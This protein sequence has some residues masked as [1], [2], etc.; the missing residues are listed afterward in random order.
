MPT[1]NWI[2]FLDG[3]QYTDTSEKWLASVKNICLPVG[4][5]PKNRVLGFSNQSL[6]LKWA[7][8]EGVLAGITDVID[9]N[10]IA[11]R[12]WNSL[13]ENQ[14]TKKLNDQASEYQKRQVEF[15][16]KLSQKGVKPSDIKKLDEL[17]REGEIGTLILYS[18][19]NYHGDSKMFLPGY[20]PNLKWVGF[21]D[22]AKSAINFNPYWCTL[23]Q[24]SWSRGAK[25]FI[26][27]FPFGYVSDFGWFGGRAS[28]IL[29]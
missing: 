14:R 10:D 1:A 17:H 2:L 19:T 4:K 27:P 13:T 21:N 24:H 20:Y 6:F 3:K 11:N 5:G 16:T 22:K 29:C 23:W 12:E 26:E 18:Q 7:K 9:K 28:S 8:K 25:F 15:T